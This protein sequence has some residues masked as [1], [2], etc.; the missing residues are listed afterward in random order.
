MRLVL[1]LNISIDLGLV[2]IL[3][4]L[5]L[6]L[7]SL[8][9]E[10]VLLAILVHI[11]QEVDTGLVFTTPLLLT[12]IPLFLVFLLGE[13]LDHA[14]VLGL[15]RDSILVVLLELLD[16]S[17]TRQSL[18]F[19]VVSHSLLLC[20]GLIQDNL[21]TI[22]ISLM[23]LLAKCLLRGIVADQL[24]VPLAVEQESLLGILLLLLLLNGPLFT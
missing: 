7:E 23:S 17:A 20:Q 21:V 19:L 22:K 11:L 10:D 9:E 18:I 14:L 5:S 3:E 6:F 1:S 13:L 4:P 16:L 12:S 8:L 2:V 15:V 24:E